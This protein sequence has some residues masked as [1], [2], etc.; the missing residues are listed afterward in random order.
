M[1]FLG[2][3]SILPKL[4]ILYKLR[5][6]QNETLIEDLYD[7]RLIKILVLLMAQVP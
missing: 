1:Y 2:L 5:N 4:L 7:V 6:I 3:E